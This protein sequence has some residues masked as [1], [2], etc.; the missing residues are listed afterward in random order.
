[1]SDRPTLIRRLRELADALEA[2][3]DDCIVGL[4]FSDTEMGLCSRF[5][6][7]NAIQRNAYQAVGL[8]QEL[9]TTLL[10]DLYQQQQSDVQKDT[11]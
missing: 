6:G 4:V 7:E 2:G 5:I 11:S 8:T 1:M 9:S 10:N 3:K